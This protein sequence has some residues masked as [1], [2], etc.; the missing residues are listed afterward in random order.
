MSCIR[1]ENVMLFLSYHVMECL[2]I[3][4]N[5]RHYVHHSLKSFTL[6]ITSKN[7][8]LRKRSC[9]C[10]KTINYIFSKHT[11]NKL[12]IEKVTLNFPHAQIS[13]VTRQDTWEF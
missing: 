10:Q 6:S 8:I 1:G 5:C 9:M 4:S 11:L 2:A 7:P 12:F 13:D 3:V